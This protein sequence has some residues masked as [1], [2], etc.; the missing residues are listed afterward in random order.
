MEGFGHYINEARYFG[1]FVIT[2]DYPPMN[3][4]IQNSVNGILVDKFSTAANTSQNTSYERFTV[5]PDIDDL[6]NKIIYCIKNKENLKKNSSNYRNTFFKDMKFFEKSMNNFIDN[7][8]S[9]KLTL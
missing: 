1:T 4:L 6:A 8:L 2:I 7:V 5:Y 3:E 9:P